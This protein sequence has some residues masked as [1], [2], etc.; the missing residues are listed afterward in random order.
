[1]EDLIVKW[2]QK[3]KPVAGIII[4]P[5]QAEGGDNHASP[6][7]FRSLRNIARK[8]GGGC[9]GKFWAHEHWGMDDPA[10][11]V[12]FSKKLLSGGYY[13]K[14]ELQA[15]KA[16]YPGLLSRARG[17]GTFCAIDLCDTAT[18]DRLLLQARDKGAK[19]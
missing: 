3:R 1:V 9:T 6:D 11:I 8:T 5:I 4:E 2:R 19:Q 17:Q 13:Q 16:Q 7:F 12:S 18:R 15:D 14:D 10:D